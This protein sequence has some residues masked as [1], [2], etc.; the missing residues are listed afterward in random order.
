[1]DTIGAVGD[2]RAETGASRDAV[3]DA[4]LQQIADFFDGFAAVDDRWH[5]RN[6][7]YHRLVESLMRFHVP[8]GASV[9]E[10]GS[11]LGGLLAALEPARGVGVDV[12]PR[13]V[14]EA[15][16]RHPG[17]EFACAAAETYVRD[18]TFDYVVL[19]DLVPFAHDLL[20][21]FKNVARM[22]HPRSRVVVHSYSEAWRPLIR[23]A[24]RLR[25]KPRKPIRNWVGPEDV[26][27]LLG[28]AGFE[29]ISHSRRILLPKRIPFVTSFLNGVLANIWPFTIFSLTYWIVARPRPEPRASGS[30]SR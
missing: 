29:V 16:M 21:I 20:A 9:L 18:D 1:M 8:R 13:M 2:R 30:E 22:T 11:G 23:L 6:R 10:I 12:S 26:E 24:E 4:A 5:R 19:S 3:A 15:A 7:T 14:D 27:N 25:L 28:L 17:L